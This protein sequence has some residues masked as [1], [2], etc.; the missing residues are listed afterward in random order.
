RWVPFSSRGLASGLVA[1][2]GR[3]GAVIAP[4][5][6]AYLMVIF[7]PLSSP[8]ELSERDILNGAALCGHLLPPAAINSAAAVTRPEYRW[9]EF[10]PEDAQSII[11]RYG[12]FI[13]DYEQNARAI[14]ADTSRHD[15]QARASATS[16]R[17]ITDDDIRRQKSE[18]RLTPDEVQ[19]L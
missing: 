9:M 10:L 17:A 13:H 5:L 4:I 6:T 14:A 15:R 11:D 12:K 8:A 18:I 19:T 1:L 7:V 2:G 3:L 16:A